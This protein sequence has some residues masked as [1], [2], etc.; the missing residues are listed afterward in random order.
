MPNAGPTDSTASSGRGI[1]FK[2]CDAVPDRNTNC[3]DLGTA[4]VSNT[5]RRVLC[6]CKNLHA[7]VYKHRRYY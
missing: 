5:V 7:P 3:F 6:F 4:F 2:L 1:T